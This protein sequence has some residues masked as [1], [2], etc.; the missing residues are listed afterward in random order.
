MTGTLLY[1]E[2]HFNPIIAE[3]NPR[4][5][6]VNVSGSQINDNPITWPLGE[7][8]EPGNSVNLLCLQCLQC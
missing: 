5:L 1:T 3:I 2:L 8:S 4:V 6:N 7:T